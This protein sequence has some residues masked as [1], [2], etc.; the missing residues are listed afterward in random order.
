MK[1]IIFKHDAIK[2]KESTGKGRGVFAIQDIPENTIV[3]KEQPIYLDEL[4][5]RYYHDTLTLVRKL[6]D[7]YKDDFLSLFPH[8]LNEYNLIKRKNFIKNCDKFFKDVPI[9]TVELY[10]EKFAKNCFAY[11][12]GSATLFYGAKFNHS[13]DPDVIYNYNK[14][15]KCFI[16]KTERN[17]KQGEE[18]FDT[19]I[20]HS[21][22][23]KKRQK[24]LLNIYGF[25]CT[26]IRCAR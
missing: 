13:C 18:I 14:K 26:C 1:N 7:E 11:K 5:G 19:Y 17:I 2:V 10:Y 8:T 22:P 3:L 15:E 12:D 23:K 25:V 20:D 6:I 16:F 24:E 9:E 4:T 21:D